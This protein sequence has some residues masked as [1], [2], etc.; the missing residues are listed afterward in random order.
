MSHNNVNLFFLVVCSRGF[1]FY[2]FWFIVKYGFQ[3]Q[4][5]LAHLFFRWI[6]N[7]K[8]ILFI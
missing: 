1:T 3:N 5:E 8:N 7:L 2:I 6:P 4:I